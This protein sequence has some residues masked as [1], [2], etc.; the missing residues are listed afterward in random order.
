MILAPP[1][2]RFSR[3]GAFGPPHGKA[4]AAALRVGDPMPSVWRSNLYLLASFPVGIFTFVFFVTMLSVGVFAADHLGRRADPGPHDAS[5]VRG[6][7]WSAPA[8]ACSTASRTPI[9]LLPQD[10][11]G[12]TVRGHW[13][14]TRQ[15]GATCYML[16]LFPIGLVEFVVIVTLG[17]VSLAISL[18][19]WYWTV[20]DGDRHWGR[21]IRVVNLTEA[22]CSRRADLADWSPPMSR[23]RLRHRLA[24]HALL[25]PTASSQGRARRGAHTHARRHGRRRAAERRRI[26][27]DLHD[28]AQQRIVALAMD[29]GMAQEKPPTDPEAAG[30]LVDEAHGEAKQALVELRELVA[31]HPPRHA[32]R[33][34]PRRR[35]LRVAAPLP[36]AGRRS[37][38][39]SSSGCR[40][41]SRRPPTSS[42]PR[43]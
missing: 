8:C 35:A 36:G 37:T 18:P 1:T 5:L 30:E 34:R 43:R 24:R 28:G 23:R 3:A 33:P 27:R 29:L 32:D 25:G 16:L 13:C 7:V 41:R 42:S 26:E 12:C 40:P 17:G 31:R 6:R 19:A 2:V 4:G 15:S 38:S 39:T 14:V 22:L 11:R 10:T 21:A 20:P 9:A